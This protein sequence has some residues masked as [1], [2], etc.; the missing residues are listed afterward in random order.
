MTTPNEEIHQQ[1]VA[2]RKQIQVAR[3]TLRAGSTDTRA[4]AFALNAMQ[5]VKSYTKPGDVIAVFVSMGYEPPTDLLISTLDDLGY[6]ILLPRV[7]DDDQLSWYRYDGQWSVDELGISAPHQT[8]ADLQSARMIFIP[9]C[10]ASNDGRR[11]GR[12]RGFYDRALA[13]V[14]GFDQGGPYRIAVTDI[15]GLIEPG[16]IP[17]DA[18][19]Q[20]VNAVLVG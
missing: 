10:A 4:S 1:K 6:G 12:G 14:S 15:A 19:D 2:L 7:L 20:T 8:S 17:I 13:T 3:N 9:A 18:H 5:F 16:L 11:L